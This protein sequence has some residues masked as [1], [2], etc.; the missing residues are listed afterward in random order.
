MKLCL[1]RAFPLLMKPIKRMTRRKGLFSFGSNHLLLLRAVLALGAA[2]LSMHWKRPSMSIVFNS[3]RKPGRGNKTCRMSQ[4]TSYFW[5]RKTSSSQ[6]L[7]AASRVRGFEEGCPW[8]RSTLMAT[9]LLSP[10]PSFPNPSHTEQRQLQDYFSDGHKAR[11]HTT[12]LSVFYSV[13][14]FLIL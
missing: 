6:W 1:N 5:G 13:F 14:S 12:P 9:G 8:A 2:M 11:L 7:A 10:H 4:G 3:H